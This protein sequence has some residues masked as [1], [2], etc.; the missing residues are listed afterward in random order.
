MTQRELDPIPRTGA[1]P[2][3][4]PLEVLCCKPWCAALISERALRGSSASFV[5]SDLA[6]R[7]F[8]ELWLRP[9]LRL[10]GFGR[11][12]RWGG[13]LSDRSAYSVFK[14]RLGVNPLPC[15][16]TNA[17]TRLLD[18]LSSQSRPFFTNS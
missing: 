17:L 1:A 15:T 4:S 7:S 6:E 10:P 16:D 11:V 9:K 18:K 3:A 2:A 8:L 5:D 12:S 13:D 14:V